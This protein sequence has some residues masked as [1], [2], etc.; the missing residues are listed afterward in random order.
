MYILLFQTIMDNLTSI[1]PQ[2]LIKVPLLTGFRRIW[3]AVTPEET[4]FKYTEDVPEYIVEVR[5]P[6]PLNSGSN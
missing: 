3:Y 1:D 4:S 2:P 5:N 6:C